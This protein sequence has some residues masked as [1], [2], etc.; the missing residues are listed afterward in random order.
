MYVLCVADYD[1]NHSEPVPDGKF[2]FHYHNLEHEIQEPFD[3]DKIH[4]FFL[5]LPRMKKIW[6][7]TETNAERWSYLIENLSTFVR[8]LTGDLFGFDSVVDNARIDTLSGEEQKE[9]VQ[10]MV[11]KHYIRVTSEAAF[12]RGIE[13]VAKKMLLKSIPV[14]TIAECTDLEP[15]EILKIKA[16]LENQS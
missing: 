10:D 2:L 1:I 15:E 13:S 9:Y 4:Y 11:T 6:Q 14:E 7:R 12:N 8:P 16:S 3:G 5:E